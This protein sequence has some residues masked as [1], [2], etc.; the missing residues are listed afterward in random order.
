MKSNRAK[1]RSFCSTQQRRGGI[2]SKLITGLVFLAVCGGGGWWALGAFRSDGNAL[3][4]TRKPTVGDFAVDIVE[5][6]DVESSAN[7]E[8]RCEISSSEGARIIEVIPEGTFVNA[9]DLVVQLDD[10][11]IQKELSGQRIAVNTAEAAKKKAENDLDAE[12]IALKEYQEGTFVQ[13]KQKLESELFVAEENF[14]RAE[15]YHKHSR[16][17]AA[18]GYITET[19]LESDRF[20]VDKHRKDLDTARTKLKVIEQYTLPK[21]VKKHEATINTASAAV[22]ADTAKHNIEL[23]KLKNLESQLAKC[24]IK[25]PTAGQVVYNNPRRWA[26]EEYF[27]RKGNRVRERQVI[28]KLPDTTKMQIKAKIGETRVDRVKPGMEAV[29]HVE[30][31]RGVDLKGTV[32]SVSAYASDENWFNANTK[33]YDAIIIVTDPPSTLKPGMTSQVEIRVETQTNVLQVPVQTVVERGGKHYSVVRQ[34]NNKLELREIEIGSSN[35]KFIVVKTGIGE[36]DDL[37]MNPKPHLAK[38]GLKDEEATSDKPKTDEN[39]K[40]SGPGPGKGAM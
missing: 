23:E 27:I 15:N 34:S 29:I 10:S 6:G 26:S 21:T 12:K 7:T 18:R 32:K 8:L 25:A 1:T 2:R 33:E 5:R 14:R 9:G 28:V 11:T 19:Q 24:V 4:I 20:A 38:L 3:I 40:P 13:E 31:L 22:T 35:D 17:L 16:T 36:Q 37:V 39:K 30:A